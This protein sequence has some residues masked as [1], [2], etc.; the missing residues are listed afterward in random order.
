MSTYLYLTCED[1]TPPLLAE[2]ESG[3]HTYDLPRIRDEIK[4]RAFIARQIDRTGAVQGYFEQHSARFLHRHQTCRIGIQ[5]EYGRRYTTTGTDETPL[6]ATGPTPH[7]PREGAGPMTQ[8]IW[9]FEVDVDDDITLK[10]PQPAVILDVKA[11][12]PDQLLIWAVVDPALPETERRLHVRGTGHVLGA[13]GEHIAT[14]PVGPSVWHVFKA[15][16]EL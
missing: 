6:P 5:D 9:K 12:A 4:H 1:H 3:Q 10:M 7:Q 11:P 15:V 8:T 16:N 13:V 2:D 14:L